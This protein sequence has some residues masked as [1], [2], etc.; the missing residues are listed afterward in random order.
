MS[1]TSYISSIFYSR[2][3]NNDHKR[4]HYI[5]IYHIHTLSSWH[6]YHNKHVCT[7]YRIIG[8]I[9]LLR[10]SSIPY[11]H[12]LSTIDC[13]PYRLHSHDYHCSILHLSYFGLISTMLFVLS[14][15]T[16][17]YDT[18]TF[19]TVIRDITLSMISIIIKTRIFYCL[20]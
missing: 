6:N 4:I 19:Y 18:S 15:R 2:S 17:V 5:H 3:N 7:L 8:H 9:H 10:K 11:T 1:Y 12:L 13:Q 14:F 16:F 20:Y